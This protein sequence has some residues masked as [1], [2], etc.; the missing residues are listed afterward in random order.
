LAAIP[1]TTKQI[2]VNGNENMNS[3]NFV[4]SL[5]LGQLSPETLA[6][7]KQHHAALSRERTMYTYARAAERTF[8]KTDRESALSAQGRFEDAAL[9]AKTEAYE[10]GKRLGY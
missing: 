1:L 6:L 4:R 2:A 7:R 5:L 3:T 9:R 8:A 10:I